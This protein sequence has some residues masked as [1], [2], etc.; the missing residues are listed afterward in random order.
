VIDLQ[1]QE[2]NVD[3]ED[4]IGPSV[5]MG[6]AEPAL[7][8][9]RPEDPRHRK[10]VQLVQDAFKMSHDQVSQRY[11]AWEKADQMDRSFIDVGETDAKGKKKNP[12]DRTVFIPTS[13]AIKD[14]LLT[15]YYQVFFGKRPYFQFDGRGPEDVM[16]AKRMEIVVDYQ[17]ERQ[18]FSL[19][20]YN[21]IND[22][23]K[24]GYANIKSLFAREFKNTFRT[25]AMP[26]AFPFPHTTYE[27]QPS[28]VL[29]Y[30]GP[31]FICSDP[32]MTFHDPRVPTS[33][34]QEGQFVG[35]AYWRS[36]QYLKKLAEQNVYF[37]IEYIRQVP[38]ESKL[39][40]HDA[41]GQER[42]R[43]M[44]MGNPDTGP[45]YEGLPDKSN[46]MYCVREIVIEI[47]PQRYKVS[48]S[49]RPE[50]WLLATLNNHTLIRCEK[51][52][53]DHDL[54]PN[55]AAEYDYDGYSL[56][57]P[58]Y[59]EGVEGL[60][61]LLN[62]LYNSHI[63]NVR[64]FL[65]NQAI[66][67]PTAIEVKDLLSPHPAKLIRLKKRLYEQNIPISSVFQQLNVQDVTGTHLKDAEIIA[68]L[69]QRKAHTPDNM[70]GV[71]TQ[72]KRTATE[73]AKMTT[74]SSAIMQTQAQVIYSQAF[75]PLAEMLVML[76]QQL[77]SEPRF[78]R[79]I[80][81]YSKEL[82]QPDL[83]YLGGN[84]IFVGPEEIQGFFDFPVQDGTL[85]M[86]AQ[87]NVENWLKILELA[88]KIPP[89]GQR[90]DLW[91]VFKQ[92]AQGMGVKNIEDAELKQ[93]PM[94]PGMV[95]GM[96]GG[97]PPQMNVQAQVLPD[98]QVAAMQQAGDVIPVNQMGAA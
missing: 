72:I 78:Y 83:R 58:G 65:N 93:L 15:Y 38:K 19:I 25:V 80:G 95:P 40:F 41:G 50:K 61:D 37:N 90:L 33:K 48:D 85:P 35:W 23:L 57:N 45:Q 42:W 77:L 27:R 68:D 94:M 29:S 67:D 98:Q 9:I 89:L 49:R 87:D 70:Q 21:F 43:T 11:K 44:G 53:Y 64:R 66:F 5:E 28:Q 2:T 59:Y 97:I 51:M 24:Y 30:E 56:Y 39:E 32:Y 14:V 4:K 18:R 60:Q 82:I 71:E 62:W 47:I 84:G 8:Q 91:W 31:V 16:P 69:I 92:A 3:D 75:V 13:R 81:E 6:G 76:N 55:V 20:G 86:R 7:G 52:P 34:I 63:D 46:P 73:I 88:V 36:G 26:Q 12:F 79:I 54:F 10:L 96:P 74:A 1:P 22:I 17:C